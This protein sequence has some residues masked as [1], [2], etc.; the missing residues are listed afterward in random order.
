MERKIGGCYINPFLKES[1]AKIK[2]VKMSFKINETNCEGGYVIQKHILKEAFDVALN[3][4]AK[5]IVVR[6]E[7]EIRLIKDRR[8]IGYFKHYE[9]LEDN[10]VIIHIQPNIKTSLFDG[11]FSISPYLLG[12]SN[13]I[14]I[15]NC[16]VCGFYIAGPKIFI[17]LEEFESQEVI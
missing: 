12:N 3:N 7:E 13:D 10:S 11:N 17:N 15:T 6:N 5:T 4:I 16:K 1:W 14:I 2:K 8:I 9:F